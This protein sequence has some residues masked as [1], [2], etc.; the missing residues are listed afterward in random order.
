MFL[1]KL[2]D[3]KVRH[4]KRFWI[5]YLNA[6]DIYRYLDN[7]RYFETVFRANFD[8]DIWFGWVSDWGWAE[9]S[10]RFAGLSLTC[11]SDCRLLLPLLFGVQQWSF[12]YFRWCKGTCGFQKVILNNINRSNILWYCQLIS[13]I[14]SARKFQSRNF[15]LGF[16]AVF[17]T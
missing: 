14:Q 3:S 17:C 12:S 16:I 15:G 7:G 1:S 8:R 11:G 6:H 10:R 5:K 9:L 2:N 13:R 4:K